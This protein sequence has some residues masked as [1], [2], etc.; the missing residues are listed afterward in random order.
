[1]NKF[2]FLENNI[3]LDTTN[4]PLLD[5]YAKAAGKPLKLS[6]TFGLSSLHDGI[7]LEVDTFLKQTSLK[8][9]LKEAFNISSPAVTAYIN[10][11]MFIE[12]SDCVEL[13]LTYWLSI[14]IV[15]HIYLKQ[16]KPNSSDFLK[17][18]E[19]FKTNRKII[20]ML[21]P[22]YNQ[23]LQIQ[24]L[25]ANF[26]EAQ[27]WDI[28]QNSQSGDSLKDTLAMYMQNNEYLENI[29]S[30]KDFKELNGIQKIHDVF[31]R[32]NAK[33]RSVDF[34]LK[35]ETFFPKLLELEKL[36]NNAIHFTLPKSHHVLIDWGSQLGHCIGSRHYAVSAMQ[37][38]CILLG[39]GKCSSKIDFTM[40]IKG[41]RICQLQGLS[42]SSPN[43]EMRS[44][45]EKILK[46]ADLIN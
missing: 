20:A 18:I 13:D 22:F 29:L 36:S 19:Q 25:L 14:D 32:E 45:I 40:E 7:A 35:Q 3:I 34:D 46:Q 23:R 37:G 16:E 5:S 43:N 28:L 39:I 4:Y 33:L 8:S 10:R 11:L 15:S 1:M 31:S 42:G 6:H 17:F 24:K 27:K 44:E 12:K 30:Q 26:T 38:E 21:V 41:R 2:P 9:A